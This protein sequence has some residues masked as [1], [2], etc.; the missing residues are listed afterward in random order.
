MVGRVE[1]RGKLLL[2]L[3]RLRNHP[4]M[5][6]ITLWDFWLLCHEILEAM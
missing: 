4:A 3:D 2:W 5:D 6:V 1:T